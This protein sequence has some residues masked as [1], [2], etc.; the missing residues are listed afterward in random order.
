ME[1]EKIIR[2]EVINLH[3]AMH[4]FTNSFIISNPVQNYTVNLTTVLR[5][6]LKTHVSLQE[7]WLSQPQKGILVSWCHKLME[8]FRLLW[9]NVNAYKK[10]RKCFKILQTN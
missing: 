1:K 10:D 2:A 5:I 9:R 3:P 8:F 7:K 6:P 4:A